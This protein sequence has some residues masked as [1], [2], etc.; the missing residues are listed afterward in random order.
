L[1]LLGVVGLVAALML[2][3]NRPAQDAPLSAT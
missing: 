2:P 1:A 3:R